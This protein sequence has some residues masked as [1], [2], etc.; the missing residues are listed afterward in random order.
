MGKQ[1]SERMIERYLV[2]EVKAIGGICYKFTSPAHNGVP[3]RICVLPTGYVHFVECKSPT[4][5]LS[6]LQRR[7]INELIKLG[8]T[9]SVV[10]SKDDVNVVIKGLI[11]MIKIRKDCKN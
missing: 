7:E 9:V 1:Q 8:C 11:E 3:D 4:G 10:R 6:V 2:S 5:N